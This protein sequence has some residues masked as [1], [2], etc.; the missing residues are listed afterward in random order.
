MVCF[1]KDFPG[2]IFQINSFEGKAVDPPDTDAVD[3]YGHTQV[4]G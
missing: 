1:K 4:F 2:L 3:L